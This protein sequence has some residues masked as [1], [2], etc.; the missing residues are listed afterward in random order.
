MTHLHLADAPPHDE[1]SQPAAPIRVVLADDHALV[2]RSLRL[3]LD[4]DDGVDVVAEA[5]DLTTVIRH[6]HGHVP[7]VLVLDLQMPNGSSVETIR[8]IR[9]E[10][11]ETEIV[12]L[13]M[14]T[15]PLFAKQALDAGAIGFVLKDKADTELPA[16]VHAAACGDEYTSPYVAAG[17]EAVRHA[18]SG[19]GLTPRETE[20]L[21]LIALGYTSRE[22][23]DRL[24]LSRRTVEGHR[25][26]IYSKL[27]L[28]TRAQ[29]VQFALARRL[30]GV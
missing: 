7:Q 28:S 8:R 21:R 6:V 12:V 4:R 11:P 26:H 27:G 5:A 17:L 15:S 20:V 2:R 16:A 13:T 14:E 22:I 24:H 10:V 18:V 19:D 30:I 25:A 1:A 9:A 29:L 3:L 23:G